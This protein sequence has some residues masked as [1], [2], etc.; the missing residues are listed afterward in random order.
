MLRK[1]GKPELTA[2]LEV[3]FEDFCRWTDNGINAFDLSDRIHDFHNG[4]SRQLY[5]RYT[6]LDPATVVSRAI[7]LAILNRGSLDAP[8][9]EK[10]T[11]LIDGFRGE[12]DG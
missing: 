1:P 4:V 9:L 2:E 3:L 8:L 11:P 5:S 12:K 10:L 7:A 6:T